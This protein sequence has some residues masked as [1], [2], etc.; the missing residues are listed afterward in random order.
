MMEPR[1]IYQWKSFLLGVVLL[2]FMGWAWQQG[3]QKD[4]GVSVST[5]VVAFGIGQVEGQAGVFAVSIKQ[6]WDV[7]RSSTPRMDQAVWF[8]SFGSV[9]LSQVN[10]SA[11]YVWYFHARFAHWFLIFAVVVGW[12]A[13]LRWRWK[14]LEGKGAGASMAAEIR[15][16]G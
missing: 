10:G 5:P 8:P 7:S 9:S 1:P 4:Q 15:S 12:S 2:A 13:W 16:E 6:S 11:P 3:M 14:R